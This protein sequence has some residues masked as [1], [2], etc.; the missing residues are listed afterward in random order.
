V[1]REVRTALELA[2]VALAP[3]KLVDQLASAAGLLEALE[4]LPGDTLPIPELAESITARS[5]EALDEW[6]AWRPNRIPDPA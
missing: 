2:L 3:P 6:H 1:R 4:D 5:V